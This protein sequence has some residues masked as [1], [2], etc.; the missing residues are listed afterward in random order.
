MDTNKKQIY[1]YGHKN[2]D[3]DSICSAIGYAWL[4]NQLIKASADPQAPE[5]SGFVYHGEANP[6]VVYVPRRAGQLNPE[7]EYVLKRFKTPAPV[8]VNDVRVQVSDIDIRKVPGIS[9][10]I[11]LKQAWTIMRSVNVAT[12]PILNDDHTLKGL[13]TTGDIARSYMAVFD[14]TILAKS[15]TP[16]ANILDALDGQ[17][18]VGDPS[19][20]VKTGKVAIAAAN[21]EQIREHI[22]E[23]DVI[24][25]GNRYE[26][27]LCAIEQ[28]ASCIIVCEGA[29]VSRTIRK[30]AEASHCTIISTHF[31]TYTV[32]RLINQSVPVSYFMRSERLVTFKTTDFIAEIKGIMLKKRH[33]DFPILNRSNKFTGMISRRSLINMPRKQLILVDHNETEQAVD[34]LNDAEVL[35]IIDHHKL[36]TVE[37]IKP[38]MVRN[39]PVGCTSTI[40]YQMAL[41]NGLDI[42][43]DIAGLLCSAIIS[44]TLLY[45]SPTCTADDRAAAEALAAIAGI[46]TDELAKEIFKAGSNLHSKS[47]EE[48]FY[49]DFKRFTAG[50]VTFGVGQ[51]MS[52]TQDELDEIKERMIPYMHKAKQN[53]GVDMVFFMLTNIIDESTQLLFS[54]SQ[55]QDVAETSFLVPAKDNALLLDGIVSRKKQLIPRLMS[56]LQQ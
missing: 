49:Q 36:G 43:K 44:D 51:I 48:I 25:L 14:N 17:L 10:D 22:D 52:M 35:E 4:K 16:Y 12:L 55:A 30:I 38:V 56:T 15:M 29:P 32:A 21:Q 45:R 13:I 28:H 1:V 40:I 11:S 23:G 47:E 34:G 53:H 42:P 46:H 2:P 33:R 27:Q 5:S 9:D 6:D 39:Q 24:I 7:T 26:T 50:D 20:C 8:Y 37:T 41:E 19:G 18:V 54:D 31:D 3:T